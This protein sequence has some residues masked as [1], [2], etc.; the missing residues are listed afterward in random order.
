MSNEFTKGALIDPGKPGS[1]QE[2]SN[3]QR[4][5]FMAG[6]LAALAASPLLVS[7][8]QVMAEETDTPNDPFILLLTGV[9]KPVVKG[10]GPNLG[11][12][13]VNLNDGTYSVTRIYPVWGIGNEG[14]AIDQDKAI[15][16]FYV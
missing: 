15:G 10:T 14:G 13:A 16:N 11:L 8:R 4:R 6:T 3:K 9:Y 1:G 5:V 7:S 2:P 12:S